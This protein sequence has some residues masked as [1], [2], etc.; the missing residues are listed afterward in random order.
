MKETKLN[1][2][3]DGIPKSV[4]WYDTYDRGEFKQLFVSIG[5][6]PSFVNSEGLSQPSGEIAKSL[7]LVRETDNKT[8]DIALQISHAI[9]KVLKRGELPFSTLLVE[10][11]IYNHIDMS[12]FV[13]PIAK[14]SSEVGYET[15]KIVSDDAINSWLLN[16]LG[17]A[18]V[19][20]RNTLQLH[21]IAQGST[22]F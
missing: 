9:S 17:E 22:N 15:N 8:S 19:D 13:E 5:A 16:T 10:Q 12:D 21:L 2:G 4:E 7:F 14:E 11:S 20:K 6:R 18:E 3:T 1:L